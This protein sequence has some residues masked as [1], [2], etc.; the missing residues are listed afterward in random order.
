MTTYLLRGFGRGDDE[1][2]VSMLVDADDYAE[3]RTIAEAI[4]G[5]AYFFNACG[6]VDK[7]VPDAAKNRLFPSDKELYAQA[8]ALNPRRRRAHQRGSR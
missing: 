8:P 2:R 5:S 4:A 1:I 7:R 3:A 6:N